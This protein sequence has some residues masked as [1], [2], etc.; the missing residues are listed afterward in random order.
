MLNFSI[1]LPTFND[2][3]SLKILL[4]RIEKIIKISKV[5]CKILIIND[6]SSVRNVYNL[7]KNK[8][9]KEVKIINL[10]K[11]IGSQRAIATGL[12]YVKNYQKKDDKFI[13][14]DSDGED[15]PE[16]IKEIINLIKKNKNINTITMNRTLRKESF[17]FSIFYE[18]HLLI[19]LIFT[20]KYLR[21]G[22]FT[23]LNKKIIK[24]IT[25]KQ[26]L[27]FAYSA[28]LKKFFNIDK[29]INAPRKKR[30]DGKSKMSYLNLIGNSLSIQYVF[31]KNIFFTYFLYSIIFLTLNIQNFKIVLV[32]LFTI[33][34]VH[35]LLF[36]INKSGEVNK[37]FF[38]HCLKNI[39][40][41]QKF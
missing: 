12:K 5:R 10:E 2:W 8:I 40:S 28:T 35:N 19:T 34:L 16:K 4:S 37:I 33:F 7:N 29:K 1:I 17:I 39:K 15:D 24:K 9:F 6:S 23:F 18:I 38:N 3:K 22:N 31:R 21:F 36:H 30:L 27:W 11:N 13:I 14:M 32:I 20:F 41:I 26:E 25:T